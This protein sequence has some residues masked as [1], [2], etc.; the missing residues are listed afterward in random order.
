MRCAI[1][2]ATMSVPPPGGNGT[3]KRI[4]FVGYLSA[5]SV[6][7]AARPAASNAAPMAAKQVILFLYMIFLPGGCR[8]L[9]GIKL[10]R[11]AISACRACRQIPVRNAVR[12][13]AR[14][15][16]LHRHRVAD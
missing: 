11:A 6:F 5:A 14:Q 13:Q 1:T 3:M 8:L 15:R 4:G 10:R 9:R 12:W 16:Q 7:P 2:R